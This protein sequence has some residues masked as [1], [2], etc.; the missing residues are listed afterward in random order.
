[1]ELT[2]KAAAVNTRETVMRLFP[3]DSGVLSVQ[4]H[5]YMNI[6]PDRPEKAQSVTAPISNAQVA[7][8]NGY[9]AFYQQEGRSLKLYR[10]DK[11]LCSIDTEF[12]I[13]SATVNDDG[14]VTVIT[15][16]SGHK[17]AIAVYRKNGELVYRWHSGANLATHATLSS[18]R[19]ELAVC[20]L[21]LE[22]SSPQATL[23]LFNIRDTEPIL[24]KDL[25][26]RIPTFTD[27]SEK[28]LIIVGFSDGISAFRRNGEA[29]YAIECNGTLKNWSLSDPYAPCLLVSEG[30]SDILY[31]YDRGTVSHRHDSPTEMNL[32]STYKNL[33]VVSGINRIQL[34]D[35]QARVLATFDASQE[36]R[37][38]CLLDKKTVAYSTGNEVQFLSVK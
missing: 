27:V 1:M 30:G 28:N 13:L 2:E 23:Y 24:Q 4:S 22:H 5:S 8:A 6:D 9:L 12:A 14:D 16:D 34:I 31:F 26:N 25:G 33:A 38:L 20:T 10:K 17:S 19:D 7:A 37:E 18:D 11:E 35:R 3:T 36:V 29:V 21:S 15:E 32:L